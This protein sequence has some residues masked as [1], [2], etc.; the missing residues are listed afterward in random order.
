MSTGSIA[1]EKVN[2]SGGVGG[3]MRSLYQMLAN[4]RKFERAPMSGTVRTATPGY[5]MDVMYACACVDIS[6]RG[7][8]ID[9]PEPL[10]PDMVVPI[11]AEDSR[12]FA[13]VCY[14]MDR[15]IGYRIGLEF[16]AGNGKRANV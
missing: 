13:R 4:R 12:R 8:A 1:L 7:M 3:W 10:L 2:R 5:A 11:Q 16:I 9:S 6:P 15:G 14:C